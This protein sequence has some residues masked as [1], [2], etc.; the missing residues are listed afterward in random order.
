MSRSSHIAL[1]GRSSLTSADS[2]V[3]PRLR[4]CRATSRRTRQTTSSYSRIEI[5]GGGPVPMRC[6]VI[7]CASFAGSKGD[8]M[9]AYLLSIGLTLFSWSAFAVDG[10]NLP[11]HDYADF[12]A[13]SAFVCRTTCGG[14]A[15][16]QAYTWV[17]PGIQGPTGHCWLKDT[18]PLLKMRVV[19]RP[20]AV[21]FQSAIYK[22]R[23]KSIVPD[24]IS[25]TSMRILGRPAR[26]P[27]PRTRSA[28]PGHMSAVACKVQPAA[29]G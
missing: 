5:G 1:S 6:L 3:A 17:K 11:G 20:R 8:R 27:A 23:T 28:R 29:V 14:E 18:L 2:G 22:Q 10:T 24:R 26:L 9:R 15:R 19:T 25:K 16:C 12:N 7:C 13:P 21:S 4:Q